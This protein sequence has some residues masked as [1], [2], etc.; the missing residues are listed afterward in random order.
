MHMPSALRA[1]CIISARRPLGIAFGTSRPSDLVSSAFIIP[2]PVVS[3]FF[4]QKVMS[5]PYLQAKGNLKA[6]H[7]PGLYIQQGFIS[8]VRSVLIS[9]TG[10]ALVLQR[11][12]G[13]RSS[14]SAEA[15]SSGSSLVTADWLHDR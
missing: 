12:R 6:S 8:T 15:M 4:L 5:V 11:I 14:T 7:A 9:R 13:Q 10:P 3:S 1:S 2:L